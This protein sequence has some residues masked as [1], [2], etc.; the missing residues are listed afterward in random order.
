MRVKLQSLH[1]STTCPIKL[2]LGLDTHSVF[3]VSQL[4][5]MANRRGQQGRVEILGVV[6]V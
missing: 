2:L 3:G 4:G 6:F 1:Q 5:R